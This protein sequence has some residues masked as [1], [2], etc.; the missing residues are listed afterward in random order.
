M[1]R[2][3]RILLFLGSVVLLCVVFYLNQGRVFPKSEPSVVIFS[4]LLTL[5]LVIFFL[6]HYFTSPT[7]VVASSMSLLLLLAPMHNS[8]ARFG[9]WYWLFFFYNLTL[10]LT[11][12]GALLLFDESITSQDWKNRL[13]YQLK[14]FS[15]FFG[16]GRFLFSSLFFLSLVFYVDSQSKEFLILAAYATLLILVNPTNYFLG[17]TSRGSTE[18]SDIGRIIGVQSKQT[19]LAKLYKKRL[20]VKRFDLVQFRYSMD[21]DHKTLSGLII[22]NFLLNEEQWIKVLRCENELLGLGE[23]LL[24]KRSSA[25]IVYKVKS[26]ENGDFLNRFVGVVVEG[27]T[28]PQLKFDYAGKVPIREGYL[29]EMGFEKPVLYQVVQGTTDVEKLESKNEAG[30]IIGEAVQLGTWEAEKQKF[31]RFGWLPELNAPV[32]LAS[33]I[34]PVAPL[35]GEI[36]IGCIPQTNYPVMLNLRD[37]ISHH[38]AILGVT[39]CG[40]SVFTRWLIRSV[41]DA[42]TKVIFVDF[43]NEYRTKYP[44]ADLSPVINEADQQ[45]LFAAIETISTELE[46]FANQ[47]DKTLMREQEKVLHDTF[48]A[49]IESFL[50]SEQTMTLFELPDVSNTT[51]ILEY[52]KFFF[53][54]LFEIARLHKNFGKQLC[55]V[56]EEAHTVIPE[57]NFIGVEEKK[58]QSLVNSIGQIA[59]Q[60]RKYDVGFIVIAQRTANV[61]KTVLTQCNS[62]IAFQQFD[63]T[64]SEFLA[65][66]VGSEMVQTLSGLKFRQAI[67]VGKGFRSG[68]PVIFE[69][70]KIEEVD[71]PLVAAEP[72]NP[73]PAG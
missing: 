38:L 42:G 65:N 2:I 4:G 70:P 17:T 32:L 31:E 33:K 14:R 15:V 55:I 61:S 23:N 5:S 56:L 39:G 1:P 28:I 57:W 41:V 6:E 49:G 54:V 19:F 69:V 59:L 63:K 44:A 11:S 20:P 7:D 34:A 51:G 8:L 43:T 22:D 36:R 71:Y 40:K 47:R 66:Y 18:S 52:T 25:N 73:A 35:P 24:P 37:A 46:K 50:K 60:G 9:V 48:S 16:N 53:K 26:P 3:Q 62:I 64:S 13:S 10:L 12:L 29:L 27:S 68:V 21:E 72:T 67:A 45:K 30:F 58:A